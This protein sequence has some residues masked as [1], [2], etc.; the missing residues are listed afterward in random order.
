MPTDSP[1]DRLPDDLRFKLDNIAAS[2]RM[3]GQELSVAE[4][5]VLAR[6]LLGEVPESEVISILDQAP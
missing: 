6:Y 2:W 1:Y 5:D 3:E 4:T